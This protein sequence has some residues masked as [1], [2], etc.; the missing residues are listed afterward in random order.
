MLHCFVRAAMLV[1]ISGVFI[2]CSDRHD[3]PNPGNGNE[4][5]GQ[6]TSAARSSEGPAGVEIVSTEGKFRIAM[7]EGFNNPTEGTLPLV[8]GTDTTYMKAYTAVR[9]TS[10]AFIISFTE[11]AQEEKAI[12]HGRV[13]DMA[14][15]AVLRNINA[16]LE[17]QESRTLNGHPGR[18]LFFT[19]DL[20]GQTLSG[21]ADLYLAMPR[22]YQIY[23]ISTDKGSVNSA[24]V[25]RA[26]NSFSLID[27]SSAK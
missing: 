21:R 9:D 1:A 6:D 13:F 18:S 3:E 10:T 11:V 2:A 22:L 26:F 23:Y 20:Q 17:R 14:R 27:S 19:G 25:E 24:P 12:D 7:P 8:T 15:D 4:G 5:N 16:T